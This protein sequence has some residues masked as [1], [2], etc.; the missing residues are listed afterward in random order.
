MVLLPKKPTTFVDRKD[1]QQGDRHAR[2][3]DGAVFYCEDHEHRDQAV[4][5]RGRAFPLV[6]MINEAHE[7]PR[8]ERRSKIEEQRFHRADLRF[9]NVTDDQERGGVGQDMKRSHVEQGGRDQPPDLALPDLFIR[10]A[11][12]M[13]QVPLVMPGQQLF[14]PRNRNAFGNQEEGIKNIVLS[15]HRS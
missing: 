2:K 1:N 6:E 4:D 7:Q 12:G 8:D 9:H 14:L 10:Q 13:V 5:A 3:Q 11:Q 15:F